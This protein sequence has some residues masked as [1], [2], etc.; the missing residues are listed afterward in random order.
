MLRSLRLSAVMALAVLFLSPADAQMQVSYGIKLGYGSTFHDIT[1]TH[2]DV[3]RGRVPA[4]SAGLFAEGTISSFFSA[5]LQVE[6]AQRGFTEDFI[7]TGPEGPSPIGTQTLTVKIHY[8]SVPLL[9]K[10]RLPLEPLSPYVL[11]G[12]RAD[13]KLGHSSEGLPFTGIFWSEYLKLVPGATFGAGATLSGVLPVT[14]LF[15]FR[16]NM[17]LK[18]TYQTGFL[19]VRNNAYDFWFGVHI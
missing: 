14:L 12:P 5:I 2:F 16:Y 3:T 6:Y 8:L 4:L 9:I 19:R 7:V 10:F 1:Y 11:V 18:N 17:D 15:E 13:F